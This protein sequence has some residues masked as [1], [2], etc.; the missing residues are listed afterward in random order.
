MR[1]S[2]LILLGVIIIIAILLAYFVRDPLF[3]NALE[4]GLEMVAGAKVEID[5]FHFNIWGLNSSWN[6][7]QI[8]DKADPWKNIIETGHA[9]FDI[10]VR[11]LFWKKF[12]IH[13][14]R[15]ENV[16]SGTARTSDGSLPPEPPDTTAETS[17]IDNAS[18]SLQEQLGD[19]PILDLGAL[20]KKL[21]VDSL[22]NIKNLLTVQKYESLKVYT[23]S[24]LQYWESQLKPATY[25][26]RLQKLETE[27]KALNLNLDQVKDVATLTITLNKLNEMY[28]EV[29]SL[30]KDI[31]EKYTGATNLVNNLQTQLTS[32]K[33]A[34]KDD[35]TKAQ[36][37]AK[38]KDMDVR[39]IS[40]LLFGQSLVGRVNEVLGYVKLG[41]KYL[42]T[43]QKIFVSEKEPAPP[44]FKGQDIHFPFHYRY[45]RFLLRLARLSGANAAGD[46]A[47]AYFFD[48]EIRGLTNQ[49]R[50]FAQ[51]TQFT[52]DLARDLGNKYHLAGSLDHT[53]E[54]AY[55]TLWAS[56][57]D[58]GLGK[59]NLKS[60]RYFPQAIQANK[61]DISFTGYFMDDRIAL[62]LDLAA[63]PVNFIF[64]ENQNLGTIA[65]II[66]NLIIAI[67]DIK[68]NAQFNGVSPK[69]Q[70]KLN[71]NIDDILTQKVSSL[72]KEN[73]AKARL[74]IE[75][76]VQTEI[77]KRRQP[78]ETKFN[79][80]QQSLMA[81][82]EKVR[83]AMLSRY[84]EIEAKKKEVEAK[85]EAEKNKTQKKIDAESKKLQDKAKDKLK[86]M[87]KKPGTP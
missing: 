37:L 61:G 32:L 21:K 38:L 16:R 13:E 22:I 75:Q 59:I 58:F 56:T 70:L 11:P 65:K 12:I 73:I 14:M 2:A 52:L 57:R 33:G 20:G 63:S 68:L 69:Y 23:D 29:M 15:L 84:Q 53:S 8:A 31:E 27:F 47:R 18:A 10:E 4:S 87:L 46:T 51:P 82:M 34:I 78:L 1:K 17:F 30:K 28:K 67:T 19:L 64:A 9:S 86:N 85:I 55:D 48:G 79:N 35:I 40:L 50:V 44:R 60:S 3:E 62:N 36:E 5:G 81:E 25:Q 45:P 7:L 49:P 42:P 83:T 41:R 26:A 76:F 72:L 77:D 24:S 39:D 6:R 66:Q 71:S 43:A 80:F 54:I 74:Q